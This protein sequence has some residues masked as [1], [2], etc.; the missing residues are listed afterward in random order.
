MAATVSVSPPRDT[1]LTRPV[2]T[3]RSPARSRTENTACQAHWRAT[4]VKPF[5]WAEKAPASASSTA[6]AQ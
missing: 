6:F 2:R 1:A 3:A 4:T 5:W